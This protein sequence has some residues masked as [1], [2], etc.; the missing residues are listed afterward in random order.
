MAAKLIFR[1][2]E[3]NGFQ[4]TKA[5]RQNDVSLV[6]FRLPKNIFSTLLF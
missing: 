3:H 5:A 1:G 4:K 6:I 2:I